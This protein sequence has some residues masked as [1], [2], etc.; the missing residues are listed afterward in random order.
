MKINVIKSADKVTFN[1]SSRGRTSTKKYHILLQD[2]IKILNSKFDLTDYSLQIDESDADFLPK[3][4]KA[5]Y[6]FKKKT[7]DIPVNY[8][9]IDIPI[10][11]AEFPPLVDEEKPKEEKASLSSEKLPIGLKKVKKKRTTKKKTEE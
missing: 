7:L 8:V 4:R 2:M 9:K 11:E 3:M 1:V 6:V 10:V 5:K